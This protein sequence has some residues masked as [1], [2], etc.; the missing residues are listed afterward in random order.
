MTRRLCVLLVGVSGLTLWPPHGIA[1]ERHPFPYPTLTWAALQFIPSPGLVV[2]REEPAFAAQWSVTPVLYSFGMHRRLS[3]W[4]S[5]VVEPFVRHGG[6]A[7]LRG[8]LDYF[9]LTP[10]FADRFGARVGL[11]STWPILERG[12]SLSWSVGTS[13]SWFDGKAA[14]GYEAGLHTLLGTLGAV[15]GLSPAPDGPRWLF[16][17]E[18]RVL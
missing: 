10:R 14:V 17:A 5:G 4:R 1:D 9:A 11:R 15:I 16:I 6:S 18:V 8:G 7:E 2:D 12:E 3:P 13:L